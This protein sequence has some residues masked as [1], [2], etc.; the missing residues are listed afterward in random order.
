MNTPYQILFLCTGNYYR[1]R[2]AEELFN[3][4]AKAAQLVWRAFSR[5]AAEQSSP[6]NIGPIS[7]FALEALAAKGI[8]PT[9]AARSPQPCSISDFG[10]ASLVIALKKAEHKPLIEH[11][12]PQ[13]ANSVQYWNVDDI[14][15]LRPSI[16]LSMIDLHVAELIDSLGSS[17]TS[18]P[19][20]HR[21]DLA[22]N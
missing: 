21:P 14:A 7:S 5:G 11:R 15:F 4:G 19:S 12:F 18:R 8:V 16:A 3:H 9:S 1:S 22:A 10:N 13:V 17:P 20:L 2:Y 6:D